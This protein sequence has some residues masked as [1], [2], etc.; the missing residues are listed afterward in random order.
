MS[1]ALLDDY[2]SG[3]LHLGESF[4]YELNLEKITEVLGNYQNRDAMS[5]IFDS[6]L[7]NLNVTSEVKTKISAQIQNFRKNKTICVTTAH[8]P[9]IFLG[10]AYVIYKI[11]S[12]IALAKQYQEKFP[13]FTFQPVFIIGSEDHDRE[14]I[15]STMLFEESYV[16]NPN[17]NGACGR[18]KIDEDFLLLMEKFIRSIGLFD[19]E[20]AFRQ[21]YQVDKTLSQATMTLIY[22]LF[23]DH[24]LLVADLDHKIAKEKFLPYAQKEC[25]EFTSQSAFHHQKN[26]YPQYKTQID[27]RKINLFRLTH[28]ART[29]VEDDLSELDSLWSNPIEISPNVLLRPILQQIM[30]PSVL[31]VGGLAE[32]TY[33]LNLLEVFKQFDLKMPR[34]RVRDIFLPLSMAKASSFRRFGFELPR[35]LLDYK[36]YEQEV[37]NEY[38]PELISAYYQHTEG[39]KSNIEAFMGLDSIDEMNLRDS[40]RG[41]A[42]SFEKLR[43]RYEK[44]LLRNVRRHNNE[45]NIALQKVANHFFMNHQLIERVWNFWSFAT[46]RNTNAFEELIKLSQS[47][48][49][50]IKIIYNEK[51]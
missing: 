12:A 5:Q 34:L 45:K 25:A 6:Q 16:W 8:Q 43:K 32:T 48:K 10:P 13:E 30:I 47:D 11:V 15:L 50:T 24:G 9:I 36:A 40:M 49:F 37:A 2:I 14:E 39:L 7:H 18:M 19:Y 1:H 27:T 44:K 28:D 29:R 46:Y 22:E 23:V 33:W 3:N 20:Q 35:I 38:F 17:Q 26:Q 4:P 51:F 41:Y 42:S 31:Q 21:A